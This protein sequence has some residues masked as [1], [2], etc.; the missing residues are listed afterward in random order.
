M[1]FKVH[2]NPD[3]IRGWRKRKGAA[4]EDL[5]D[6]QLIDFMK[7]LT[8]Q[9]AGRLCRVCDAH[10]IAVGMSVPL[11][12]RGIHEIY[13]D[14][15]TR[16]GAVTK[17]GDFWRLDGAFDAIYCSCY[18]ELTSREGFPELSCS[19]ESSSEGELDFL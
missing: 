13:A 8:N 11:C 9:M 14:Y 17:F 5:H 12:T 6:R 1:V 7:E 3:Q 4:D 19:D 16:T 18:V 2:F 10:G 15:Q